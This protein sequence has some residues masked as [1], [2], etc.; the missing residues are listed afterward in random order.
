MSARQLI[1]LPVAFLLTGA[2]SMPSPLSVQVKASDAAILGR[3][4]R[5]T[6]C[7]SGKKLKPCVSLDNVVFIDNKENVSEL[8]TIEVILDIGVREDIARCCRVGRTYLM[9]LIHNEGRFYPYRGKWS[10]LKIEGPITKELNAGG[11]RSR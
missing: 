4:V 9:F 2:V 7:M 8:K 1:L 11:K 5:N 10:I 3:A 6:Q